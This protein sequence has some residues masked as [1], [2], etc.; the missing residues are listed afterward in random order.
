[1]LENLNHKIKNFFDVIIKELLN[2]SILEK[3]NIYNNLASIQNKIDKV[4]DYSNFFSVLLLHKNKANDLMFFLEKNY[5]QTTKLNNNLNENNEFWIQYL[6]SESQLEYV[7]SLKDI[8]T[9]TE[10]SIKTLNY[11]PPNSSSIKLLSAFKIIEIKNNRFLLSFF[12]DITNIQDNKNANI[13]T[14]VKNI[15]E[16]KNITSILFLKLPISIVITNILSEIVFVNSY[17]EKITLYTRQEVLYQNPK[18]L[19]SGKT[20]SSTYQNLWKNLSNGKSWQGIF[21]NKKKNKEIYYEKAVIFSYISKEN[22]IHYIAIKTDITK[23]VK[24]KNKNQNNFIIFNKIINISNT[25]YAIINE[26]MILKKFNQIFINFFRIQNSNTNSIIS[27]KNCIYN[28]ELQQLITRVQKTKLHQEILFLKHEKI[29]LDIIVQKFKSNNY[30]FIAKNIT[31]LKVAEQKAFIKSQQLRNLIRIVNVA[32]F[33][34]TEKGKI[35]NLNEK[36]VS[37]SGL[38]ENFREYNFFSFLIT[39]KGETDANNIEKILKAEENIETL[40]VTSKGRIIDVSITS[41]IIEKNESY[42]TRYLCV[43]NDI[44]SI[45]RENI[46]LENKVK[47]KT[48]ELE[49][50]LEKEKQLNIFKT[51][52]VSKTS[53]EFRTPLATISLTTEFLQKYSHKMTPEQTSDKL[54]KILTQTNNI[55]TLLNNFLLVEKFEANKIVL[56]K[57]DI[58]FHEFFNSIILEFNY[59]YTD[60][61]FEIS[62][63]VTNN[64]LQ[65]DEKVGIS[66][67]QNLLSNA[68][69]YSKEI[70][71]IDVL[72]Y[73]ENNFLVVEIKDYGIGIPAEYQ[74]KIF[75]PFVRADNAATYDGTGLGLTIVKS[76]IEAHNGKIMFTSLQNKGTT[77][78]VYLPYNNE[79][80]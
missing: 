66:I 65:I 28:N 5:F 54:N 79:M 14:K 8:K 64:I 6:S 38:N 69:K 73:E 67:F 20:P 60:F 55:T 42:E 37:L 36:A 34:I 74:E 61:T 62:N 59:I 44:T 76:S 12:V 70:K 51:D 3:K 17:F 11:S 80:S 39:K 4:L 35:I 1:M 72:I 18:I 75:S 78:Y 49:K 63:K 57:K 50:S 31:F 13:N 77:F 9:N 58:D 45:K 19:N 53:H 2:Y 71:K 10:I 25:A 68:I 56:N 41:T 48:K 52:F 21:I 26:N 22:T 40:F 32:I 7:N 43:V 33:T 30:L 47:E 24:L 15:L 23:N 29:W 16:Y 46:I 27:E